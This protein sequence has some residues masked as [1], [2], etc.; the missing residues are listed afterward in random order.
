MEVDESIDSLLRNSPRGAAST[1]LNMPAAG[2]PWTSVNPVSGKANR[3]LSGKGE[4]MRSAN[5]YGIDSAWYAYRPRFPVARWILP[6]SLAWFSCASAQETSEPVRVVAA[7]SAAESAVFSI[8]GRLRSVAIGGAVGDS[9]WRLVHI[10]ASGVLV[11]AGSGEGLPA[12]R[13]FVRTGHSLPA[14]I[15]DIR[16]PATPVP[17][18]VLTHGEDRPSAA[19]A[20][21]ER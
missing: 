21:E 19:G 10:T 16:M 7:H 11:E 2:S 18:T 4:N 12:G 1:G 3:Y 6:L 13:F 8:D 14:D 9:P 17:M 20:S 15:P 5:A